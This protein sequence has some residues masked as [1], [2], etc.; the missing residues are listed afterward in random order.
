MRT[1]LLALTVSLSAGMP[2][3]QVLWESTAHSS[4]VKENTSGYAEA[5]FTYAESMI[6]TE[7]V[8][9]AARGDTATGQLDGDGQGGQLR[10]NVK[11]CGSEKKIIVFHAPYAS[12]NAGQMSCP[13]RIIKLIQVTQR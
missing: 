9:F 6:R 11:P 12:E 2:F 13:G 8:R 7:D 1:I 5:R 3:S 4:Q 10:L